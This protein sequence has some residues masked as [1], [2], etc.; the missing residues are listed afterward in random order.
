MKTNFEKIEEIEKENNIIYLELLSEDEKISL[1]RTTLKD[2][3]SFNKELS[4]KV[5]IALKEHFALEE[6]IINLKMFSFN[7]DYGISKLKYRMEENDY[8]S[9]ATLTAL[10]VY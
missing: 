5:S 3:V 2:F 10:P 7:S 6:E 8:D 1:I 9:E 4:D